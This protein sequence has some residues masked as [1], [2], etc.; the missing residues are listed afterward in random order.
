MCLVHLFNSPY[1]VG[2]NHCDV[3][4][5]KDD[6]VK[7]QNTG[8]E[9]LLRPPGFCFFLIKIQVSNHLHI[10][11]PP[12][13]NF[14]PIQQANHFFLRLTRKGRHIILLSCIAMLQFFPGVVVA[15][16]GNAG[17]ML[18][19]RFLKNNIQP[20]TGEITMNIIR[21]INTADEDLSIKP[22]LSVPDNWAVFS[23]SFT[24]T[25]VPASDSVSLPFSLRVPGGASASR[26]HK[27]VFQVFSSRNRLIHADTLFVK[28]EP[29]H[30]WDV[31]VPE[32]RFFF[33]PRMNLA[34]FR[35]TLS[36][37][38]N[39]P[40]NINLE[41][42]PDK[43]LT[44]ES[45]D[46]S[47]LVHEVLVE[48]GTDTTIFYKA[49][50]TH[51]RERVFDI[52]KVQ[53]IARAT[54]RT[55]YRDVIIE[56]YEDTYSP[57]QI[58]KNKPHQAEAG[59]RTF[60]GNS[61]LL[62]YIKMRGLAEFRNDAKFSYSF[63]YHDLTKT[64]NFFDN[65]YYQF[66]YMKN[67][68][69][70][71]LGAFSSQL[72]RNLYC[73]NCF[74][75]SSD[76]EISP[77][78]RITGFGSVGYVEPKNNV[79][80]G[81]QYEK[82]EFSMQSSAAYD[83]DKERKANTASFLHRIPEIRLHEKHRVGATVYS[84]LET[85]Q[86][87]NEYSQAGVAYDLRYTALIGER[88]T[89]QLNN[90]FGSSDIPGPQMG[91]FTVNLLSKFYLN[92]RS[93]Y[94][95]LQVNNS[96]KDYYLREHT[97]MRLP[98]INLSNRFAK[99]FYYSYS[100]E[101]FK[102]SF[103]PSVEF[104][105]SKNPMIGLGEDEDYNVRKY[106]L[107][108]RALIGRSIRVSMKGG[109]S[110]EAEGYEDE[111]FTRKY[112]FHF[113]GDYNRSGYGLRIAYD[114]GPM[115]NTGLYQYALDA[116]NN[117]VLVSPY[118][119]KDYFDGLIGV[120]MFTNL[121]YKI[122]LEYLVMNVNPRIETYLYKDWYFVVG[123]TYS[124]V[125][126]VYNDKSYGRSFHYLEFALKKRWGKS[127]KMK[128]NRNFVRLKVLM[129][130]DNNGNGKRDPGEDGIPFV[131]TRILLKSSPDKR[132]REGLPVDITLLS[133]EG[134]F[135]T[136][137]KIPEGYYEIFI[138]P[139]SETSEYFYVN[140]SIESV[141]II[142][143]MVYKIPFQKARKI[144]GQIK[145][146]RRKFISKD[147][148]GI[149]LKNIRVTAYNQDG[150]SYSAFTDEQGRFILFAPG[151][152]TYYL[153]IENV[154]GKN[155]R[156]LQNDIMVKLSDE[157]LPPVIFNVAES[158]RRV[159]IKKSKPKDDQPAKKKIQKIKVLSGEVYEQAGKLERPDADACP[160]FD[161]DGSAQTD[162][163]MI[164]GKYY[165]V[166]GREK[167]RMQALQILG[168]YREMGV[169]AYI[170]LND[171]TGEYFVF[172][173]YFDSKKETANEIRNLKNRNVKD[174]EIYEMTT[175][176]WENGQ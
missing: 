101:K 112:D 66:L 9:L 98:E 77:S 161:I 12:G 96:T 128:Y 17:S 37:T 133:N 81:Y 84:Y 13:L 123:G 85:H 150:H 151:G 8:G 126:Q 74:M 99:L 70:I 6:G 53:V 172:T 62:P 109:L 89:V 154:F 25:K 139:L 166:L 59:F 14:P 5:R 153:R 90:S 124:Y 19:S 165:V 143:N 162:H 23:A 67:S 95:S 156:I 44:V 68:L 45:S 144:T 171:Y 41:I 97:G 42:R 50:Y 15:Q 127:G 155:F 102:W 87:E 10:L 28:P 24:E 100:G 60:S 73:R 18:K 108:Y 31:R 26:D 130:Q 63:A 56:K 131:K 174:A 47:E 29:W 51:D 118:L 119:I 61:K 91:L 129:F 78:S 11:Q 27:I 122:D 104:Y 58:N 125:Q 86:T 113:L 72:G 52:S 40:E 111:L 34:E 1:N 82:D 7:K 116:G 35:V 148:E 106:R 30:N 105:R 114:Y 80:I 175:G 176:G 160:E 110:Q 57:L 39:V 120:T 36:N 132:A 88:A 92:E 152:L 169:D 168:I 107:E 83:M 136:F 158:N 75:L 69:N 147:E 149:D 167:E 54:G 94:F 79:G 3:S 121:T 55:L 43:K 103:G 21:V 71:G 93:K 135:A 2:N 164:V 4:T 117:S 140:R 173:R 32:Q 22:V 145:V 49:S 20:K 142:N 138:N 134:G 141:E 137:N 48:P 33:Y 115:V 159:N 46:G 64:E 146:K 16:N 157:V 163:E 65:S 170:G 76:L 38:G